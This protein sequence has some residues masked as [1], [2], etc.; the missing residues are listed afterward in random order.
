MVLHQYGIRRING[1]EIDISQVPDKRKERGKEWAC[2]CPHCGQ[3]LVA[4]KGTNNAAH[5]RHKGTPCNAAHANQTGLHI[6]AKKII[7]EEM[8]FFLPPYTVELEDLLGEI[9]FIPLPDWLLQQL[10]QQFTYRPEAMLQCP[11]VELEKRVSDIIPDVVAY[12]AQGPYLIEIYVTNK[13]T[14]EKIEKAARLSPPLPL[15]E[16]DLHDLKE[17]VISRDQLREAIIESH[18][19]TEWR[20]YPDREKA[21]A[22]ARE[23]Y[24]SSQIVKNYRRRQEELRRQEAEKAKQKE[25]EK[26][27]RAAA[28]AR[29][30][31]LEKRRQE[32][33]KKLANLPSTEEKRP[34]PA[35]LGDIRCWS[36]G[37][38]QPRSNMVMYKCDTASGL[39]RT[40]RYER[41]VDPEWR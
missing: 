6:R 37:Q 30:Q 36:C 17:E 34:A 7:E 2:D 31:E 40:C 32:S 29:L 25:D 21:L 22:A 1:E 19:R 14:E 12:T 11:K 24:L 9:E 26:Q 23:F 33:I 8:R 28:R 5:F 3:P 4:A 16:V 39:C 15:L 27:R 38:V 18:D 13:V 41:G 20:Y 35:A 10:P